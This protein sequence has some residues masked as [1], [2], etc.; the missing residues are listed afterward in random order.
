MFKAHD[1]ECLETL[2]AA[3]SWLV[4][5]SLLG[6]PL[7][8]MTAN[9]KAIVLVS[10]LCGACSATSSA[11]PRPPETAPLDGASNASAGDADAT[12]GRGD[13]GWQ[14]VSDDG[15]AI[16]RQGLVGG[17]RNGNVWAFKGIPY[18]AAPVGAL[19]WRPPQAPAA[20]SGVRRATT[21]G[22]MCPQKDRSASLEGDEDCLTLNVWTPARASSGPVPVLVFIHGGAFM[23]GASSLP[24]YDGAKLANL[25]QVVV[26]MNY[27]LGLLGFMA[28][29][30][31]S[32][33]N[34]HHASGNYG[35]MDQ[36]AALAWVQDNVAAFG[37]DPSRVLLFGQSAGAISTCAQLASERSRGL[38]SRAMMLSGTCDALPAAIAGAAGTN[39][40]KQLGCDTALDVGACLRKKSVSEVLATPVNDSQSASGRAGPT[41]DGW[42]LRDQPAALVGTAGFDRVPAVVATTRDEFEN[43]LG[44]YGGTRRVT[45]EADYEALVRQLYPARANGILALYPTA[46]YPSPNDALMALL[47]DSYFICPSRQAARQMARSATSVWRAEFAHPFQSGAMKGFAPH[48]IDLVFGFGNFEAIGYVPNTAERDLSVAMMGYWSRFAATGDPNGNGAFAW[49]PYDAGL[50]NYLAQDAPFTSGA[51]IR[52]AYCNFWRP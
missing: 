32:A 16:T 21:F 8:I 22:A 33:E 9:R 47:G 25:G 10:L 30:A 29:E 37:G 51:G 44:K 35:L 20:W 17:T 2:R 7:L 49:S 46:N 52:T 24:N 13:S 26:T 14:A 23:H 15:I 6:A 34:P 31:L 42:F 41:V 1:A 43:Q 48:G 12:A 11:P 40:A 50:D 45:S 39:V 5:R 27:R 3:L 4:A 28:H 38:F 19:R 36:A 18:A